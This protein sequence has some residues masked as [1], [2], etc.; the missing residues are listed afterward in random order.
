MSKKLRVLVVDDNEEFC[1][2][3]T[4]IL[5]LK[6]YEVV[7]AY[8]GFKGLEAVKE[9]GFDLVLMDVKMPVMDGVETYR[10]VKEIAPDT[11]VIMVTADAVEP[12][13]VHDRVHEQAG[14]HDHSWSGH[15]HRERRRGG[16]GR[17]RGG[18]Q[19]RAD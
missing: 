1:Q 3:I 5:E 18:T 2:N 14:K 9:D 16:P 13:G 10:K 12:G 6:D 17:L 19:L 4:D 15:G 11:P 8:D 7:S